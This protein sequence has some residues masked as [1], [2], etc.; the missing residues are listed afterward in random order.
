VT[1]KGKE[2]YLFPLLISSTLAAPL[3][4]LLTGIIDR[5]LFSGKLLQKAFFTTKPTEESTGLSLSV[6]YGFFKNHGGDISVASRAGE[7][8]TF[9]VLLPLP[10]VNDSSAGRA[11]E[12]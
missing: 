4:T 9:T 10:A 3:G 11:E 5:R 2:S 7:G 6:S 12:G 8:A 1:K